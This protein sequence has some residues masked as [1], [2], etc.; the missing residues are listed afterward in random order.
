MASFAFM[1]ALLSS[2]AFTTSALL[3]STD[4]SQARCNNVFPPERVPVLLKKQ[5]IVC[6]VEQEG[7][8]VL[9][10]VAVA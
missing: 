3:V 2:T 5:K 4:C 7:L 9:P 8:A 1:S 10:F 6:L